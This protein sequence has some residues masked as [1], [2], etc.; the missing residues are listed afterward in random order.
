MPWRLVLWR[1]MPGHRRADEAELALFGRRLGGC[2][3]DAVEGRQTPGHRRADEAELAL[4]GRRLSGCGRL[5]VLRGR[6]HH[7]RGS[8]RDGDDWFVTGEIHQRVSRFEQ[9][10]QLI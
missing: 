5:G 6:F 8:V 1:Q 2:C 7:G 3:T 10:A 4:F 9:V